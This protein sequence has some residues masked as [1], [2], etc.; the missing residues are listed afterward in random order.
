MSWLDAVDAVP[1]TP[2]A[3]SPALLSAAMPRC[4]D[5]DA[6]AAALSDALEWAN[7]DD[8]RIVAHFLAQLGHESADLTRLEESL[9]Y[10]MERLRAVWPRRFPDA[11]STKGFARNPEALANR[12]YGGRMG[13]TMK[14]DGWRFRG[15]GPIQLTGR[16]N[17]LRCQRD[18]G[19]PLLTYPDRLATIPRYGAMAAAWYWRQHVTATDVLSITRQINGGLNGLADRRARYERIT[20]FMG[21]GGQ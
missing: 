13:N 14:G 5:P 21:S 17:Y 3:V 18:T 7:I 20:H 19:L 12:V 10:T 1:V 9:Y 2:D 4:P 16:D 6:W 15:R 11:A 8:P